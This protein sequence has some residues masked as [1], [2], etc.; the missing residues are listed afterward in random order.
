[1][2][3]SVGADLV[4]MISLLRWYGMHQGERQD[5]KGLGRDVGEVGFQAMVRLFIF[6]KYCRDPS[7]SKEE[8]RPRFY[9]LGAS[10]PYPRETYVG[11]YGA[12]AEAIK[13]RYP[14]T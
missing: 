4:G 10:K 1:M 11:R 2:N 6:Y 14:M 8:Q 7:L 5:Q 13:E 9:E 3:R 12:C